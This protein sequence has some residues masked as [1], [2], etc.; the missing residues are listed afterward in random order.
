M[1]W[2]EKWIDPI[3]RHVRHVPLEW[4]AFVDR[5][6]IVGGGRW[7]GVA[8]RYGAP[9][10]FAVVVD[11]REVPFKLLRG[12]DAGLAAGTTRPLMV[13]LHGMGVTAASFQGILPAVLETHDVL[14]VDYN[15]FGGRGWPTGGVSLR[16]MAAA[17][18]RVVECIGVEQVSMLGSSLGGGLALIAATL[19]PDRVESLVLLNPAAYP[20]PLPTMYKMARIPIFGD[21]MMRITPA[22]KFVAGVSYLGYSVPERMPMDL[23]RAYE[24]NLERV[25]NRVKLMDVMR[26]LSANERDMREQLRRLQRLKTRTM[27]MWGMLERLLPAEGGRWLARDLANSELVEFA[28]LAHLP[29]EEDPAR[30][31]RE[32]RRFLGAGERPGN[33]MR[34]A[35]RA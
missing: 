25:E 35:A 29:H 9:I 33:S 11:G 5:A 18:W 20:Q 21:V 23:R 8:D 22:E 31:S 7:D 1:N 2:P 16:M 19:Q 24:R 15:S 14:I 6:I 17:I 26:A 27:V 28:D 34:T 12:P 3:T 30:I 13:A 32:I 10:T 4:C